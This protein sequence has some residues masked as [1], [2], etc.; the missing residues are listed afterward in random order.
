MNWFKRA[1]K[2]KL[3]GG[4]AE[5]EHVNVGD[6]NKE[7][8]EEGKKEEKEHTNDEEI[9]EEISLDHLAEDP[10]YYEKLDKCGI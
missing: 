1:K 7:Q 8:L 4:I 2:G 3:P 9:A 6:V 5:K 10:K